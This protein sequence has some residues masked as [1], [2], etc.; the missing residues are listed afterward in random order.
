MKYS[1]LMPS[2]GN[3]NGVKK[4]LDAFTKT[5]T[6]HG[7]IEVLIACDKGDEEYG[8]KIEEI[9]TPYITKVFFR[10]ACENFSDG[11][12]NWLAAKST[13]DAIQCFNDDAYYLTNGW[14]EIIAEKVHGK[15]IWF[16]DIWD[17]TRVN[18]SGF[19]PCFPM[20]SRKAYE[21]VGFVLHPQIKAYPADRRIYEVYLMAGKVVDCTDVKIQHDRV[22]SEKS[23]LE[24]ISRSGMNGSIDLDADA[25]KLRAE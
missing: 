7:N 25:Q 1:I 20:V 24:A 4:M 6:C 13:G 3:I 10:E 2:K 11:Y 16:A 18:D 22:A 5:L 19:Q 9:W 8:E 17:S 12:Y 14:D 15:K 21:A 23:R